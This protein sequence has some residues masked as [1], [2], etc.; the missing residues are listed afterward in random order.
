MVAL[1][2]WFSNWGPRSYRGPRSSFRGTAKG[3]FSQYYFP[4]LSRQRRL[5]A[6][7]VFKC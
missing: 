7:P 2:Q 3:L 1:D 4:E 6:I 5:V